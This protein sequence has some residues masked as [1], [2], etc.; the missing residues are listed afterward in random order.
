MATKMVECQPEWLP[1]L[2]KPNARMKRPAAGFLSCRDD[3]VTAVYQLPARQ[4]GLCRS[5]AT[6]LALQN[7]D[8]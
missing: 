1:I 7:A 6:T 5:L 3:P 2:V 8:K 4:V